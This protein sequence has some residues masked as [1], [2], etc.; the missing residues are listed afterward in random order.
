MSCETTGHDA[1]LPEKIDEKSDKIGG[2]CRIEESLLLS[3]SSNRDQGEMVSVK[4][5]DI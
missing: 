2:G 4:F 5:N 1:S 3:S